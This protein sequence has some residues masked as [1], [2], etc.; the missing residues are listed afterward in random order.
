MGEPLK[1]NLQSVDDWSMTFPNLIHFGPLKCKNEGGE[2][3][4][5]HRRVVKK[6]EVRGKDNNSNK[7][8]RTW[9]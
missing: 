8:I 9:T 3:C 4:N 7:R 1:T 2:I 5:F 6:L